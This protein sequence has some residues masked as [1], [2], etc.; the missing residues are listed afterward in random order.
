MFNAEQ[1]DAVMS[2][3]EVEPIMGIVS[4]IKQMKLWKGD[5]VRVGMNLFKV[6]KVHGSRVRL[7]AAFRQA[8]SWIPCEPFRIT[9]F[10]REWAVFYPSSL[11]NRLVGGVYA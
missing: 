6:V 3:Y 1:L 4:T 5:F 7:E 9:L 10:K 8:G 11:V 2:A